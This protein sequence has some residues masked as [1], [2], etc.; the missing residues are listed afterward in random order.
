MHVLQQE[1]IKDAVAVLK[2]H[3]GEGSDN[4]MSAIRELEA[5]AAMDMKAFQLAD[6]S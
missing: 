6:S 5:I 4:V 2:A 1:K 3:F